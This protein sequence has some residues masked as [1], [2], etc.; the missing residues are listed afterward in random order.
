MRGGVSYQPIVLE[1]VDIVGGADIGTL[2][3]TD[4]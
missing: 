4:E 1:N 2:Y 3:V